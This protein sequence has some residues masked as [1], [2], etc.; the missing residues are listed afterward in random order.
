MIA[1]FLKTPDGRFDYEASFFSLFLA[2][3][4]C[5]LICGLH[6][7]LKQGYI[8]LYSYRSSRIIGCVDRKKDSSSFR[9]V[10]AS[11]CCVI[12]ACIFIIFAIFFRFLGRGL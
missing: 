2:A 1:A 11:N 8:V 5:R 4:I 10:I 3:V 6:K 12:A 9:L 7:I